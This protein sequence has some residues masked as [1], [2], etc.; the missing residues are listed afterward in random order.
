MLETVV[1]D[2]RTWFMRHL[3]FSALLLLALTGCHESA[4]TDQ[5]AS[6]AAA[7]PSNAAA[8]VTRVGTDPGQVGNGTPLRAQAGHELAAF[9]AGCFW[10]VEDAFRHVPGVTATAVGYT[11]G[12]TSDPTYPRVC[13]H[14]TG[15]AE[16]V[17]VEFEP[18]RVS[19]SRLLDIFFEIHDP[20]TLNRQGPDYGDQYRSAVFTQSPAQE[21]AARAALLRAQQKQS[22]KIVTEITPLGRFYRAEDYH[23]QYAERT[24]SHGCP[25]RQF[26]VDGSASL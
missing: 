6:R 25:I 21:Q 8:T 16:T 19:Y 7:S 10:G 13:E 9:A 20:T 24:G 14:D 17:L 11:G 23:Q 18:K 22:D 26:S 4:T 1:E 2:P 5:R 15:H 3:E 12:H